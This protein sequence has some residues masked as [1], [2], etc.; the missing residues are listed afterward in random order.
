MLFL[1]HFYPLTHLFRLLFFATE[2]MLM[3]EKGPL[4]DEGAVLGLKAE[5]VVV[6]LIIRFVDGLELLLAEEG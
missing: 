3:E 4:T 5:R 1:F 2:L 6:I